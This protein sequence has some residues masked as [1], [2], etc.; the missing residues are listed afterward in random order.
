MK[1]FLILL[2]SLSAVLMAAMFSVTDVHAAEYSGNFDDYKYPKPQD[3]YINYTSGNWN[4]EIKFSTD[5]II[6]FYMDETTYAPKINYV[7]SYLGTSNS[8]YWNYLENSISCEAHEFNSSGTSDRTYT[9]GLRTQYVVDSMDTNVPIFDTQAEAQAWILEGGQLPSEESHIYFKDFKSSG[10]DILTC[11]WSDVYYNPLK[12]GIP[13][14]NAS[15]YEVVIE[16]YTPGVGTDAS[17]FQDYQGQYKL[18]TND[19][20]YVLPVSEILVDD[21]FTIF[22][23][24]LTPYIVTSTGSYVGS[25]VVVQFNSSGYLNTVVKDEDREE[26][27]DDECNFLGVSFSSNSN[28]HTNLDE[29]DDKDIKT[30]IVNINWRS[31]SHTYDVRQYYNHEIV[32]SL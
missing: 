28:N 23:L 6:A 2:I 13:D 22:N 26:I 19:K 3:Y 5:C 24:K 4:Y 20:R 1:K 9:S 25:T 29:Y 16:S 8:T 14:L 15:Y 7:F 27:Y 30:P 11:T 21:S 18:F 12:I 32:F 17:V 10:K 31:I